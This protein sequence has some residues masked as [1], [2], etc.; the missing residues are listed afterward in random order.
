MFSHHC[1]A[2]ET[3]VQQLMSQFENTKIQ[4]WFKSIVLYQITHEQ[5]DIDESTLLRFL[6][7]KNPT[8]RGHNPS[9]LQIETIIMSDHF[10]S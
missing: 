4:I 3:N 5:I 9:K 6:V 8:H 1:S 2:I 10:N 7:P